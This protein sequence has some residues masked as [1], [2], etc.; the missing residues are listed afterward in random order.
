VEAAG[1]FDPR[2]YLGLDAA[3][4]SRCERIA[5]T[6]RVTPAAQHQASRRP[7]PEGSHPGVQALGELAHL[8]LGDA[9]DRQDLHQALHTPGRHPRV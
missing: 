8:R 3:D 1:H 7:G 9:L 6:V 5:H 2:R 4:R